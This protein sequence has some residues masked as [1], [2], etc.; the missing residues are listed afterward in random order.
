MAS[1]LQITRQSLGR[2]ENGRRKITRVLAWAVQYLLEHPQ[3]G[4]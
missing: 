1:R 2:Y 3:A 4:R